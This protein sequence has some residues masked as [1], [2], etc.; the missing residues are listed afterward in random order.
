MY[1]VGDSRSGEGASENQPIVL[2][3]YKAQ[4]L[5]SLLTILYPT[6]ADV[7]SGNFKL[8]KDQWIG[9]LRLATPWEMQEIR[10]LAITT[11][12]SDSFSLPATEKVKLAREHKVASWL[13]EGLTSLACGT[14][15]LSIDALEEAVTARTAL[16]IVS[17]Q[18][19][20][21]AKPVLIPAGLPLRSSLA[22][23]PLSSLCCARCCLP[24]V[25]EIFECHS[26]TRACRPN[27]II[28]IPSTTSGLGVTVHEAEKV[29][30]NVNVQFLYCLS[31]H[32][33]ICLRPSPTCLLQGSNIWLEIPSKPRSQSM[34][35]SASL[36]SF[37]L[38]IRSRENN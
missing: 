1:L 32:I 36:A 22:G 26:C 7:S 5:E 2:E 11:L 38:G 20:A 17:I 9:V 29:Y 35:R 4:D 30:L 16:R 13:I 19:N 34:N 3:G 21:R 6:T 14:P 23:I 37:C 24:C 33:S 15:E 12:S 18:M 31:S 27:D 28:Y 25:P 8:T 10:H